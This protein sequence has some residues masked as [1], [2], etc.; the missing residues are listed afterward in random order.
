L[1]QAT[2]SPVTINTGTLNI[3]P[4]SATSGSSTFKLMNNAAS[5][6]INNPNGW[7]NFNMPTDG[8]TLIDNGASTKAQINNNSGRI[9]LY[10]T[11]GG[12]QGYIEAPVE[13]HATLD[14]SYGGSWIFG[15]KDANGNDLF[16]DSGT[17]LLGGGTLINCAHAYTQSGGTLKVYDSQGETLYGGQQNFNGGKITFTSVTGY[18]TLF[19]TNVVFGAVEIDMRV[20][21]TADA[22]N[23]F[24]KAQ[25]GNTFKLGNNTKLVVT[26]VNKVVAG[27]TWTLFSASLGNTITNNLAALN[28]TLPGGVRQNNGANPATWTCQS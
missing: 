25:T 10:N 20:D 26:A 3:G 11:P 24:I 22:A 21:G 13:N 23:D 2:Y 17:F 1:S 28:I 7:L 8:T 18:E 5:I 4:A 27:N 14:A 19:V 6:N 12:G 9:N 16:M 15:R